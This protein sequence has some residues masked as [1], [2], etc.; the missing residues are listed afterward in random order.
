MSKITRWSVL[1]N[2]FKNREHKK[3]FYGDTTE[4]SYSNCR[5]STEYHEK[6]E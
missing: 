1:K 2:Y 4:T 3:R 5:C 6:E